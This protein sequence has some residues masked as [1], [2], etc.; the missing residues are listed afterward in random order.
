MYRVDRNNFYDEQK[1]ATVLTPS[2]VSDFLFN[3]LHEKINKSGKVFDPCVGEGS[4]LLPFVDAGFNVV[5]VDIEHQGFKGT[6]TR[7]FLGV[8]QGT[9]EPPSLV[10]ANPPFNIDGK[11][12][13]LA[14]KLAGARPLLPEVWLQKIIR[15]W[16]NKL[17]ICLF[18]PYGLRLNQSVNSKRWLKFVNGDYPEISS[19]VALPKDIYEDVLFHSE[20]LIFNVNGLKGHYFYNG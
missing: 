6:L 2:G 20:I 5:G 17:P 13:E 11:T 9:F 14:T 19:I 3:L 7:N 18:A 15:L 16:G 1:N 12:K 4:L 8:R 10:I